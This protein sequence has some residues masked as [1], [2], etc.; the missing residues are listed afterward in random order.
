MMING[1]ALP[2][3]QNSPEFLLRLRLLMQVDDHY[4]TQEDGIGDIIL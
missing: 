1:T 2:E 4:S 3:R